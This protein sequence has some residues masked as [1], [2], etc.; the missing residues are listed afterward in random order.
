MV[1]TTPGG[2]MNIEE[3]LLKAVQQAV[4]TLPDYDPEGLSDD[5]VC[6]VAWTKSCLVDALAITEAEQQDQ[7]RYQQYPMEQYHS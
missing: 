3:L 2:D 4:S 6:D 1:Q 5:E 7:Q